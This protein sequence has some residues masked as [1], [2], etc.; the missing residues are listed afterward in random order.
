M[1]PEFKFLLRPE[2]RVSA[3]EFGISLGNMTRLYLLIK[4][5]KFRYI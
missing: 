5:N 4:T 3:Q 2:E 1:S